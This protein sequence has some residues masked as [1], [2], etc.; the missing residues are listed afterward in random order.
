MADDNGGAAAIGPFD[1]RQDFPGRGIDSEVRVGEKFCA[2]RLGSLLRTRRR[3]RDQAVVRGQARTEPL[4]NAR[5]L[6]AAATGEPPGR[7]RQTHLGMG[8]APKDQLRG[9]AAL[10]HRVGV[11]VGSGQ[12]GPRQDSFLRLSQSGLS[13]SA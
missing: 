1:G 8:M 11:A 12:L 6:F 4:G 2:E 10:F 7:I 3:A 9:I 13:Q 5:G